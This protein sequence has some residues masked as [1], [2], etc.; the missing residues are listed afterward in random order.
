MYKESMRCA[1]NPDMQTRPCFSE[2]HLLP[3]TFGC[4]LMKII[5]LV[6]PWVMVRAVFKLLRLHLGNLGN[7]FGKPT[8]S[9]ILSLC[10]CCSTQ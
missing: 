6:A 1:K 4:F 7:D 10:Y 2:P 9:I 8:D 5:W 3:R